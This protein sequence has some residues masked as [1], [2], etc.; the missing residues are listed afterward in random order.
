MRCRSNKGR[1]MRENRYYPEL[2]KRGKICDLEIKNRIVREP[3]GTELGNPDGSPSWA[4]LK[5]Y[6]EAAD[7]GPGTVFMDNA[8]VTQF[9]HVGLSIASDPY[10]GP[11]SIL[12]KTIKQHGAVPGLQIVH[13]GRDAAFVAGDEVISASE[14]QWEPWYEAGGAVPR[15]LTIDE[16]HS[17]VEYFGDAAKRAQRAGFEIV[18]VHAACGVLLSNFLSPL[19]NTRND[20]YG[21]SLHNRMRF[22]MEVI[23]NIKKK[24]PTL[25]LSV[26]LSGCDFEPGG[27]TIDETVEV[28][29][30]CEAEGV[31]VINLTWGSHAEVINAAGLLS[32]HGANHVDMAV[33]IKEA[34]DI[35]VMLC[36]GIYTP[37]IGEKLLE[38]GVCDYVGIGKPALA[39]PF[40]AKKAKEGRPEDIRPC[41]GCVVGCH[42]RGMLSGGVVQCAV[43]P[44]LFKYDSDRFPLAEE[45]KRVAVIG[46]GPGGCEAALTLKKRGHD[47]T[48]YDKRFVGGT[49]KE[50]SVPTYKYDVWRLAEYYRV[51]LEKAG[52]DV[53]H[54]EATAETIAAGSF[55]A[56]IVAAGARPRVLDFPGSDSDNVVYAMDFL[57]DKCKTD[58]EKVTVVGGGIV[59]AEIALM[60]AE[61]FDKDVTLTTRQDRFFIDGCMGI[62]YMVRLKAAGVNVR[63]RSTLVAVEEGNPVFAA[64]KGRETLESDLVVLSPGF[65]PNEALRDDIESACDTEVILVGDAKAPRM[66]MDAVHE[67]YIAALNL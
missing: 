20:L 55:D 46:A 25:P 67:G 45:A 65:V 58:A 51:Q 22:L 8:G 42:D 15:A 52:I 18:D 32:E 34:V 62:A 1:E 47:V 9:H 7:G 29:K 56:C 16:I 11:L 64:P 37:E 48:L 61:D 27:I 59:G 33:K 5:A 12:A 57:A 17:F 49:L 63:T 66:I 10:I 2:F 24:C 28:V 44:R 35:P 26:R 50:A 31:D 38:D 3:M 54:Q 53:V 19:N 40:W 41:I 60:L 43:N 4:S 39:D 14:V 30:A 13:P 21:G 36:G 23:R 6:G